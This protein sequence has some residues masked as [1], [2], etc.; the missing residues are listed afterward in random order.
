MLTLSEPLGPIAHERIVDDVADDLVYHNIALFSELTSKP[1]MLFL[2]RKGAGKSAVLREIRLGTRPT[3]IRD[4]HHRGRPSNPQH[5][6]VIDVFSWRHFHQIVRNVNR[7]FRNEDVIDEMI[8]PE[9]FIELWH[10]MLWDEIIQHFYK[11]A[12]DQSYRDLL[13]PVDCYVNVDGFFDGTAHEQARFV[14]DNAKQSVLRFL[15]ELDANLYFLFDSMDE[16]PVRN[17]SFA[18]ILSG[19]FQGLLKLS[20]ESPRIVISFCI[21]EE[22]EAFIATG[23]SNLMKDLSSSFRI[24]WNPIDLLRVVAHR[25]RVSAG[26]YDRPLHDKLKELNFARRQDIHQ[27]FRLVLPR[28]ITNSQGTEEDALAYIIRHT[29]LLPRHILA[30]FNSALSI[31]YKTTKS[32][33]GVS[34]EAI[35]AGVSAVQKLIANQ[36]LLPFEHVYP[37]LLAQCR[38]VL[39]DLDPIC[40]FA[41][42]KKVDGR[43]RRLIEDDVGSVWNTLFEMGVIGRSTAHD[44]NSNHDV[45]LSERYCYGQFHFNID[46]SFGLATDGEYCFH[47]VFTRAFGMVRRRPDKRVVYPAHIN[48]EAL[49]DDASQ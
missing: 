35:R 21:P 5:S 2:G 38:S 32:F 1:H 25:L 49:Y 9:Y 8:P 27:L 29:Q 14:F 6:F 15:D 11:Y 36:I 7:Q 23:S 18:R 13:K 33:A 20:D 19:L 22:I 16:Y 30:I 28:S 31:H 34:Q 46:G 4:G 47:P 45:E 48:L 37:K 40:D 24:R 26:V 41:T 43:F 3:T 39:P 44:G 10:Q 12:H 17:A 42:L